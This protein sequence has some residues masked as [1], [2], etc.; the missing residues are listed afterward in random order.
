MVA[1][2]VA[3][4]APDHACN[5]L[6]IPDDLAEVILQWS[7]LPDSIKRAILALVRSFE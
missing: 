1:G 6:I 4:E 3:V 7:T 5:G 2:L